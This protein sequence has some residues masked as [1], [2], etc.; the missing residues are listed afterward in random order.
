MLNPAIRKL[1]RKKKRGGEWGGNGEG[2]GN[3]YVNTF[4]NTKTYSFI[5]FAYILTNY[6]WTCLK[7]IK[8]VYKCL[9]LIFCSQSVRRS[10]RRAY[11][12]DARVHALYSYGHVYKDLWVTQRR[13]PS[14]TPKRT[15]ISSNREIN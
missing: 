7:L 3:Q 2:R 6:L 9:N 1:A 13:R 4:L 10:A 8:Y 14:L 5:D 12:D 15:R 11:R